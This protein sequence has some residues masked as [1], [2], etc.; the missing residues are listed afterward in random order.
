MDPIKDSRIVF[1]LLSELSNLSTI[2]PRHHYY[3]SQA[4]PHTWIVGGGATSHFTG[5]KSDFTSLERIPPKLVKGMNLNAVA[6]GTVRLQTIA[7]SKANRTA[8]TCSISLQHVMYVRNVTTRGSSDTYAEPSSLSS[9]A[10][11]QQS[12]IYR[13]CTVLRL[14]YG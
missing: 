8:R 7:I 14:R 12:L 5:H 3:D 11:Y 13:C 6:I 9:H 1:Q 10:Q 2:Y 4:F